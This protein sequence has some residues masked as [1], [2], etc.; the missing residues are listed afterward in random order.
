MLKLSKR[1]ERLVSF[2]QSPVVSMVDQVHAHPAWKGDQSLT[3]IEAQL[4]GHAPYTIALSQGK[5]RCHFILSYVEADRTVQHKDVRILRIKGD[6]IFK[7]CSGKTFK[8]I[9]NLIPH[10]L[11]CSAEVCQP[12]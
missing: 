10:C 9:R 12:L 4:S 3:V 1:K 5:E 6:W 7:N 11:K 8:K 2:V